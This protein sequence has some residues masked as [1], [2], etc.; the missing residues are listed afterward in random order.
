MALAAGLRD[1]KTIWD[2]LQATAAAVHGWLHSSGPAAD[3]R[4]PSQPRLPPG[5]DR[6][7][8]AGRPRPSS[9]DSAYPPAPADVSSHVKHYSS[10]HELEK[11]SFF[12]FRRKLCLVSPLALDFEHKHFLDRIAYHNLLGVDCF[13]CLMDWHRSRSRSAV[14]AVRQLARRPSL[15][16][17]VGQESLTNPEHGQAEALSVRSLLRRTKAVEMF[18]YLDWD[19]WLVLTP[20]VFDTQRAGCHAVAC[21]QAGTPT[22]IVPFLRSVLSLL[23]MP[24]LS[25]YMAGR[26]AA[27]VTAASRVCNSLPTRHLTGST[28]GRCCRRV[29]TGLCRWS[30]RAPA[31]LYHM[32]R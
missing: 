2:V 3:S 22:S 17:L 10:L 4:R 16:A 8:P 27:L 7:P 19:E 5:L 6:H 26:L 9:Q 20:E 24:M 15:V 23:S 14:H 13:I 30:G 11:S 12:R 25:T 21:Q 1:S 32:V 29:R 31:C 28:G 18:G